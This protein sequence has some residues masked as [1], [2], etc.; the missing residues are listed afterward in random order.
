VT[1][2]RDGTGFGVEYAKALSA[3]PESFGW[4]AR[5]IEGDRP[6]HDAGVAYRGTRAEVRSRVTQ[7]SESATGTAE[8][9]GAVVAADGGIFLANRIDDAFAIVDAGA[10][11]VDV[12]YE[13]RR[14]ATTDDEGRALVPGLRSYQAAK[15]AI[16][17]TNLPLDAALPLAEVSVTPAG[18][19]GVPVKFGVET[20][21]K[22][23]L[24]VVRRPDGTFMPVG[25]RGRLEGGSGEFVIGYDG[26]AYVTDLSAANI[27]VIGLAEGECR[28][29]FT[30]DPAAGTQT[31]IDPVVCR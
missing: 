16:D 20:G 23:A 3:A 26:Q 25:T 10:P 21:V 6:Q 30:Y 18:R 15:I 8:I 27:A 1:H 12:L 17:P 19:S 11:G 5:I 28:A 4:Q 9:G 31:V 7:V 22:S 24:L 2:N 13:N 14:I 29:E